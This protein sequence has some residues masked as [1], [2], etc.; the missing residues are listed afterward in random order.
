ME[1]LS[2]E[3]SKQL[4]EKACEL[5]PGGVNSPVRAFKSVDAHPLF[6]DRAQGAYMWDADGNQFVDY[7]GSWG[8]AILGHAH[9][10]VL[11]AVQEALPR[12][13]TFGAP[14]ALE[15]KIAELVREIMPSMQ[16]LRLVSSGTEACM[17][18]LRVARGY[19][20]REKIVKFSGCYH[21]HADMLLVKAGSGLATLGIPGSPGVPV[22]STK[23]T[24]TL[25]FNDSAALKELFQKQGR[26]IAAV[27]IEPFVGN[28]NFIRP[29]D[30]YLELLRELT[31]ASGALLIFDEVMT[32][33]RV[34]LGGVQGLK[35]ITPDLTTLGKVIGGGM[36]IGAYGGKAAIMAKVAPS[37]PIYQAGTLS[38]N[39]IAV[40]CGIKTLEL[41]RSKYSFT[42]LSQRT[43]ALML[44]FKEAATRHGIALSVDSEGGMFGFMFSSQLPAS[45]EEAA[46][47]RIDLFKR[48]FRGMLS[49]GIY[50]APSAFEA[51]FVSFA[52]SDADVQ[53]TLKAADYVFANLSHF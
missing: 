2:F 23:D 34:G 19:T 48:F 10:E 20:G 52:H 11:A 22:G 46:E 36:P 8:P 40:T 31:Q 24:I 13:F 26:E 3:R 45:Y 29:H 28:A 27:I 12:G 43:R 39:P 4:Y 14:S 33:F 47:G 49:Q 6:I 16:M 50:L 18:A 35:K 30:G 51:G 44:G 42:D 17:A 21:G 41:L 32:G 7:I 9:P 15:I 25:T 53:K 37:G 38:G 5:I 1:K